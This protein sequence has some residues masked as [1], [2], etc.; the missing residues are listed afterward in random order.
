[1]LYRINNKHYIDRPG[2]Y[3]EVSASLDNN[4]NVVLK[5]TNNKVEKD[6]QLKAYETTLEE[7]KKTLLKNDKNFNNSNKFN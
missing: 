7:I 2:Y 5:P 3:I 1:M 4:K 6:S